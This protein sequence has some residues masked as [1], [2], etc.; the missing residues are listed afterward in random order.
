[1]DLVQWGTSRLGSGIVAAVCESLP[2][3]LSYWIASR[4]AARLACQPDLPMTAALSQNLG[5][6]LG[7]EEDHP[8]VRSAVLRLYA[9]QLCS[10]VDLFSAM[11]GGPARLQ[12]MVQID[13]RKLDAIHWSRLSGR[14]VL[15]VG[16][17]T[18][19]FDLLMLALHLHNPGMQALTHAQPVGGMQ[20]MNQLRRDFGLH[21]TPICAASLREAVQ[22][23]R[24]GGVVGI[25]ADLPDPYGER[26]LFFDR[27][28]RLPTGPARLA[29]ASGAE[30]MVGVAHRTGEGKYRG[31]GEFCN[32][33]LRSGTRAEQAMRWTQSSLRLIEGFIQ[34]FPDQWFVPYPVWR[35]NTAAQPLT[36]RLTA[37]VIQG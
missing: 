5:A 6:V 4:L 19:G 18:C 23:L 3:P 26:M 27:T 1:M 29:L 32:P 20:T 33:P 28:C 9:N 35:S 16:C 15:V 7:L 2:R 17:H 11:K 34:Q 22:R 14:G 36:G 37:A 30:M 8:V 31:E 24:A 25:A 12:T 13:P 10:Y 21:L